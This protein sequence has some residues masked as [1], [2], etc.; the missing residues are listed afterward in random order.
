[1]TCAPPKS[2]QNQKSF[3]IPSKQPPNTC[4]AVEPIFSIKNMFSWDTLLYTPRSIFGRRV[5]VQ[6]PEGPRRPQPIKKAQNWSSVKPSSLLDELMIPAVVFSNDFLAT[7]WAQI[8]YVA[9]LHV[10]LTVYLVPLGQAGMV[11]GKM[12]TCPPDDWRK[13]YDSKY[14]IWSM[15]DWLRFWKL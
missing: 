8:P 4:R 10:C 5:R 1:M 6:W 9:P 13:L 12:Q 3:W 2:C 7:F 15:M 11:W 14:F